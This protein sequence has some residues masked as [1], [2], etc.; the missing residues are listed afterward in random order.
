MN[1]PCKGC[2]QCCYEKVCKVGLIEFQNPDIPCPG[3]VWEDG[4]YWCSLIRDEMVLPSVLGIGSGCSKNVNQ[5]LCQNNL[6]D[7]DMVRIITELTK[8]I[9]EGEK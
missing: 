8:Q 4:R 5:R 3:L 1:M 9:E 7:Q 6:S 2:G